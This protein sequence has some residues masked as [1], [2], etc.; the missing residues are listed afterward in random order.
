M[1]SKKPFIRKTSLLVSHPEISMRK[2]KIYRK[3]TLENRRTKIV[4]T[5]G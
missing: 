2:E 1:E 5:L 4:C 3:A